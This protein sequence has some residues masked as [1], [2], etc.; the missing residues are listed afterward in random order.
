MTTIPVLI[1]TTP[2]WYAAIPDLLCV[3]R[4]RKYTCCACFAKQGRAA[5]GGALVPEPLRAHWT[6]SEQGGI[7]R[8]ECHGPRPSE[9]G[10]PLLM[11]TPHDSPLKLP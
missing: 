9:E 11:V 7:G 6:G 5:C 8:G 4:K 10:S 1:V 3:Q 2:P